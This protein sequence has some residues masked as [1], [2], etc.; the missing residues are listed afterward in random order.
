M[1]Y[2]PVAAFVVAL[3]FGGIAVAHTIEVDT[4][5]AVTV[6]RGVLEERALALN[7]EIETL[8]VQLRQ[9][10]EQ[11]AGDEAK[12][13]QEM[14]ALLLAFQPSLDGF[15]ETYIQFY[16]GQLVAAQSDAQRVSLVAD[17]DES[18]QAIKSMPES[19]RQHA[20]NPPAE[21]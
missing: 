15:I 16:E 9:A 20:L 14:D 3:S 11:A 6:D 17:R 7:A 12:A 1:R 5:A 10:V 19:L 4:P 8:Q 18:V 13:H 21:A 2:G